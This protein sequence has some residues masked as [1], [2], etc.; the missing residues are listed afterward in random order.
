M[1]TLYQKHINPLEKL[2]IAG[3]PIIFIVA[4]I[5]LYINYYNITFFSPLLAIVSLFIILKHV[6]A[7][8]KIT[9]GNGERTASILAGNS[10]KR[11]R[12]SNIRR[13]KPAME[14]S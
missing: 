13:I 1:N 12:I 7:V 5:G 2:I 14:I 10:D 3:F 11:Q 8:A 4:A 6:N 9:R